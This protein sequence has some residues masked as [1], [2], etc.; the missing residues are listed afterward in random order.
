MWDKDHFLN[1]LFCYVFFFF[2]L[3]PL[4]PLFPLFPMKKNL[5]KTEIFQ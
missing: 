4:G 2:D 5:E 1:N 3:N